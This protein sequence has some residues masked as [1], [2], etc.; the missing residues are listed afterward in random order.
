LLGG[1]LLMSAFLPLPTW[2]SVE[3]NPA[4]PTVIPRRTWGASESLMTWPVEYA[5]LQKI[6]VHHT[7]STNL[8]P[9]TD[10][11]GQYK[12]MVN[13]I[14]LFHGSQK[15]WIDGGVTYAGFGDIGYNYIIDPNGNIYEGRYGGN[16]VVAG[17]AT[18]FNTGSVGISVIGN[19]QDGSAT[20]T[21]KVLDDKVRNAL[22]KLIG[23]IAANNNM[24]LNRSS[25]FCGK[26]TD[27]VVAHK[28]VAATQCPG[29]VIYNQLDA[30]QGDAVLYEKEYQKY[31]YQVKGN[32]AVY[33]L[34]GGYKTRYPSKEGLPLSYQARAV[35][36]ISQTQLDA[37]Q[38]KD[39][40]IL[41]DGTLLQVCDT[42]L[43]YY[44]EKSKKRP[45]EMTGEQFGKLVVRIAS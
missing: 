40:R 38:Y 4:I 20:Q 8:V 45:M 44:V 15:T 34:S 2:A 12:N 31:V 13:A 26:T 7:A 36:Y 18:G 11:S 16:G 6:I 17:H 37:Y 1:M 42:N 29:T 3:P 5:P 19:Y 25:N 32:G 10:G 27:G 23:W 39:R 21:N 22:E 41:P 14:Y 24:D 35:Q 28:D 30:I 33:V 43:V 9:D